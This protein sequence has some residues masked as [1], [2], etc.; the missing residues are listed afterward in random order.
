MPSRSA[1]ASPPPAIGAMQPGS[2][3]V[4]ELSTSAPGTQRRSRRPSMSIQ[5][6]RPSAESQNGDSP[7]ASGVSVIGCQPLMAPRYPQSAATSPVRDFRKRSRK[8]VAHQQARQVATG[9]ATPSAWLLHDALVLLLQGR[10][11]LRKRK[12]VAITGRNLQPIAN[13]RER[14]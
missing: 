13:C 2:L 8:L 7:T 12:K 11:G 14:V 6:R 3:G 9:A 10:H 4:G 5:Y 1:I